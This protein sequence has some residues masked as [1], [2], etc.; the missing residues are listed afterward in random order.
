MLDM[1]RFKEPKLRETKHARSLVSKDKF[2]SRVD[3]IRSFEAHQLKV[4][5]REIGSSLNT[6]LFSHKV[7]PRN[8][9]VAKLFLEDPADSITTLTREREQEKPSTHE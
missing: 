7:K 8:I 3:G 9:A 6:E 4:N 1:P 2:P 5:G